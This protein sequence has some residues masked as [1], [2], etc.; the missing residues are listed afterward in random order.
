MTS[1]A[2]PTMMSAY[3]AVKA[4]ARRGSVHV[5]FLFEPCSRARDVQNPLNQRRL[6]WVVDATGWHVGRLASQISKVLQGKHKPFYHPAMDVGDH[7]LVLNAHR[8]TFSGNK[9]RQKVYRWHTGWIGGLKEVPVR[10]WRERNPERIL[11]HAVSGMLPHNRTRVVRNSR[12]VCINGEGATDAFFFP[13]PFGSR[14]DFAA[15]PPL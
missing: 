9:E 7:V 10:R 13:P 8:V 4:S 15:P 5:F 14:V 12:L 3:G 11:E 6:W 2:A 1:A